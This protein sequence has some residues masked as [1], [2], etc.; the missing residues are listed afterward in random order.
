MLAA[1]AMAGVGPMAAVAGAVAGSI[2]ADLEAEFGCR[3]IV[4]ENGGD[5]WLRFEETLEISVFAGS[6]PLSERV[7]VSIPP[8]L[9]PLGVCTSSGTVG[10]SL[11]LGLAD[12]AMV[13]VRWAPDGT[14]PAWPARTAKGPPWPG[15]SPMRGLRP[16]AMRCPGPR[17]STRP[18]PSP[19]PGKESCPSS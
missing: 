6:S 7:G 14:A 19:R 5:I 12:A 18:S 3:E 17:T 8:S 2:G 1:S 11:S 9:S 10:P 4:V 13:A 16:S 15:R